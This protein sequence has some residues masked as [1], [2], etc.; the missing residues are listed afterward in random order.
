MSKSAAKKSPPPSETTLLGFKRFH[1]DASRSAAYEA[2][3][4]H[5]YWLKTELAKEGDAKPAW[6]KIFDAAKWKCIY[7]GADLATSTD[8]IAS[9]TEEHLVPRTLIESVGHQP[10]ISENLTSCCATCNG[11]KS[12]YVPP[13]ESSAW[14][15][16]ETYIAICRKFVARRRLQN[17]E[18]YL[19]HLIRN[20]ASNA[21]LDSGAVT[22][23]VKLPENLDL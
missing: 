22:A 21:G 2:L 6:D 5:N 19:P 23:S 4:N 9:T 8:I 16:K 15:T 18:K 11:L 13:I 7:C 3:L 12:D 1:T 10:N 20:L 17:F 14:K